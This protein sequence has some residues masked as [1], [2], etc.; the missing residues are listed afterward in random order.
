MLVPYSCLFSTLCFFSLLHYSLSANQ[1]RGSSIGW[2]LLQNLFLYRPKLAP[3]GHGAPAS[4]LS[5]PAGATRIYNQNNNNNNVSKNGSLCT[6]ASATPPPPTSTEMT[7][8]SRTPSTSSITAPSVPNLTVPLPLSPDPFTGPPSPV[9]PNPAIK[10]SIYKIKESYEDRNEGRER[11]YTTN[12]MTVYLEKV[13]PP[14]MKEEARSKQMEA[15]TIL[16]ASDLLP[17][18]ISYAA[19]K[20]TLPLS[21]LRKK[22]GISGSRTASGIM[23]QKSASPTSLPPPPPK[24]SSRDSDPMRQLLTFSKSFKKVRRVR[25]AMPRRRKRK[26]AK[27]KRATS[28]PILWKTEKTPV[29]KKSKSMTCL[30]V[31][32][33][34]GTKET[35][36]VRL[37]PPAIR[38]ESDS[39]TQKKKNLLDVY[40]D[41]GK[42]WLR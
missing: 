25:S 9:S 19:H 36:T 34:T 14:P 27:I 21:E 17:K 26:R 31:P 29:R 23:K 1:R 3:A 33:K 5:S 41:R 22:T 40:K 2:T 7:D 10:R 13:K 24:S 6:A 28:C 30:R 37:K 18:S 8:P 35:K 42:V 4:P 16:S 12:L 11:I 32:K 20:E 15:V 39:R 38:C